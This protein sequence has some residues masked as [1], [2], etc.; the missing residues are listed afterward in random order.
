MTE[1]LIAWGEFFTYNICPYKFQMKQTNI[2]DLGIFNKEAKQR[3]LGFHKFAQKY[4]DVFEKMN[5]KEMKKK[6]FNDERFQ[7]FHEFEINR[8]KYCLS[9][10]IPWMPAYRE[11]KFLGE[12]FMALVDRI[13]YNEDGTFTLIEYKNKR[14][15][16]ELQQMA[17]YSHV[18]RNNFV[19]CKLCNKIKKKRS[20]GH[21][22]AH[23]SDGKDVFDKN[24]SEIIFSKFAIWY[25]SE[26]EEN[27]YK[28]PSTMSLNSMKKK[29]STI[30][31]LIRAG[32]FMAKPGFFCGRCEYGTMGNCNGVG[33]NL[34]NCKN[35]GEDKNTLSEKND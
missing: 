25:A 10:N 23:L 28:K 5:I 12:N 26:P 1:G 3:G 8:K 35:C 22:I 20:N 13:D 15:S 19:Y 32:Y 16:T 6:K 33:V 2:V 9:N 21:L 34:N 27:Y 7:I 18:I 31:P 30:L 4:F 24:Q 29:M 11:E 14:G 17:F